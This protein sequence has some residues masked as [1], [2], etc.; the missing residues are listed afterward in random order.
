MSKKETSHKRYRVEYDREGCIGAAACFAVYKERWVVVDD[1]KADLIG[2][3]KDPVRQTLVIGADE[4]EK[5]KEAAESCPVNVI[6]IIDEETGERI[7]G[8]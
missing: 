8:S 6:H 2:A 5:M 3:P 1:G 4:F 7:I